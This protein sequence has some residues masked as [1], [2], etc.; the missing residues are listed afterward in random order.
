MPNDRQTN[1]VKNHENMKLNN[2]LQRIIRYLEPFGN[3]F[4]RVPRQLTIVGYTPQ[5]PEVAAVNANLL[6]SVYRNHENSKQPH[7][8]RSLTNGAAVARHRAKSFLQLGR[9]Y[10]VQARENFTKEAF[11]FVLIIVLSI[12]P[13]IH[14]VQAMAGR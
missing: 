8:A 14:A 7:R 1:Q 2:T 9:D 12:W 4:H 3:F 6:A 5:P 10:D 11:L 13:I